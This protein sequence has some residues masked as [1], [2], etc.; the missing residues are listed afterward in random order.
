MQNYPYKN[1]ILRKR[2]DERCK[3][4]CLVRDGQ[5]VALSGGDHNHPPHSEKIR[6]LESLEKTGGTSKKKMKPEPDESDYI[7]KKGISMPTLE[8]AYL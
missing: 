3:A 8:L 5:V 1:Y 6:K 4:R 7:A 2:K